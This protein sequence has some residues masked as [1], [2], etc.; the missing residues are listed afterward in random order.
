MSYNSSP[1]QIMEIENTD[2]YKQTIFCNILFGRINHIQL[3]FQ[4]INDISLY[5]IFILL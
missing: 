4:L 2:L 5:I 3:K 1:K